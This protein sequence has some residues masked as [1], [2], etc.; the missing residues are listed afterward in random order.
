LVTL[1]LWRNFKENHAMEYI[2]EKSKNLPGNRKIGRCLWGRRE[3]K[4]ALSLF[5]LCA[6]II[7]ISF[8]IAP[9]K[10]LA[11]SPINKNWPD[12]LN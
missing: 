5:G 2:S 1:S 3:M 4:T 12:V 7:I 9:T 11:K 10:V 6:L 8:I